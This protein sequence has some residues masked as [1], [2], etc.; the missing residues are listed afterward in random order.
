[1]RTDHLHLLH[2]SQTPLAGDP[3][4]VPSCLGCRTPST[5]DVLAVCTFPPS[6]SLMRFD[7]ARG[8]VGMHPLRMVVVY[9][10]GGYQ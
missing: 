5:L 1:M 3:E 9:N 6:V 4:R 8:L 10:H 2:G 7:P